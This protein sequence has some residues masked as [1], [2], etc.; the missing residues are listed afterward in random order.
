MHPY[1]AAKQRNRYPR[2]IYPVAAH[3][4][5]GA[6]AV[7]DLDNMLHRGF[8]KNSGRPRPQADLDIPGFCSELRHRGAYSGTICRNRAFREQ[9]ARSWHEQGYEVLATGTNC[10][11]VVSQEA[12]R[13]AKIGKGTIILVAGDGDYEKLVDQL[14]GRGV[15]VE[16]WARRANYSLKLAQAANRLG[17]VDQFLSQAAA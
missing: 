6:A 12:L 1:F 16:V 7:V 11:D 8:D 5:T 3:A 14:R 13:Y 17:F 9:D 4:L 2:A 10:D 15:Y